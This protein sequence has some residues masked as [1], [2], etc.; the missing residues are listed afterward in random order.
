MAKKSGKKINFG[1]IILILVLLVGGIFGG[2]FLVD[3]FSDTD[4]EGSKNVVK[5]EEEKVEEVKKLKIIDEE[6]TSRPIAVMINNNPYARP[7]HSGLQDAYLV[8]EII[9]EGGI[10]RYM[11]VFKDQDTAKIGSV[12]SSRHYFLDY[13]LE[14][15]AVYV[16]WGWSPQA[17]QQIKQYKVNNLDGIA[18]EGSYFFRDNSL[19]VAYEHRGFTS[20]ELIK[21]GIA[22]K[23][24]NDQSTKE[25]LLNYSIDEVDLSKLEGAVPADEVIIPYSGTITTSYKYDS[26]N[27]VY[28]RYVNNKVHADYVTKEQFTAK[29]IITYKVKNWTMNT[30]DK[31][32]Q[33]IDNLGT[34]TGY[35]IS[36]GYAVPIKW[37]KKYK[38]SQTK[39]ML[40]DGTEIKVNDGNTYIQIQPESKKLTI[41]GPTEE[42][43]ES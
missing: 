23:G 8:Y 5:K 29:N 24:Y 16:H 33:D 11:A 17:E 37:E 20:M 14:N 41:N 21:K 18:Y 12:R 28:L 26:A 39:Y 38:T 7:Y 4:N 1:I 34:G 2:L 9:V 27:K 31:G 30:N 22:K 36:D 6:S 3:K 10:T 19:K 35:Y 43:K 32:R 42:V 15:D 13:A 40:M 25:T